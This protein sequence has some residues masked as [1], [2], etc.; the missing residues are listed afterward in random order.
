MTDSPGSQNP[1]W[2]RVLGFG[3]RVLVWGW[4][5]IGRVCVQPE[6]KAYN[7]IHNACRYTLSGA[8]VGP[9]RISGLERVAL[10]T[11]VLLRI[12]GNTGA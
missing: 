5:G 4:V 2:F 1:R 8:A 12:I 3:F 9:E 11:C 6:T 10:G 7:I